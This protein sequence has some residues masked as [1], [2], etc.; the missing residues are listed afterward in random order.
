MSAA[1]VFP[2]EFVRFPRGEFLKNTWRAT[3]VPSLKIFSDAVQ[4]GVKLRIYEGN[5][6]LI[7]LELFM[8]EIGLI[9]QEL[10]I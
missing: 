6:Q 3:G 10:P 7:F 9:I 5:K 2:R 4:N 8:D 1:Q